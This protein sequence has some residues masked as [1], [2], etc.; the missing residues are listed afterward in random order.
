MKIIDVV[1]NNINTIAEGYPDKNVIDK[2]FPYIKSYV[3]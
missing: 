3:L 1:I 2:L